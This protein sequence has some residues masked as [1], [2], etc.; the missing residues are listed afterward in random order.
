M[1]ITDHNELHRETQEPLTEHKILYVN[2]TMHHNTTY[3][4]QITVLTAHKSAY[5]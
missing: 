1:P 5:I 2:S 4:I 3:L